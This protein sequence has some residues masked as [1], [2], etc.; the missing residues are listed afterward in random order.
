[1]TG[2]RTER[3]L[4]AEYSTVFDELARSVDPGNHALAVEIAGLPDAVRGYE[5]VKLAGVA[6][7]RAALAEALARFRGKVIACAP[8]S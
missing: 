4:V 3:A 6:A 5:E 8:R 2:T 7:Y 1:V